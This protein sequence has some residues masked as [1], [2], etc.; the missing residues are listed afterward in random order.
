MWKWIAVAAALIAAPALAA[1]CGGT[2]LCTV[3]LG[4]YA[5]A[6]PAGAKGPVPVLLHL[7]GMGGKADAV[8]ANDM[9]RDALARGYAMIAPQGDQ[10]GTRHPQNWSVSDRSTYPRDD[11]AFVRQVL[12]DAA[13]RFPIDR[14][15]VLMSGFSRGGS[16]VW[17]I[18][19]KAPGMARAYAPVAGAFWDPLPSAC[20]GPVDM[21]HT[22]GW[23]DRVVPLEGRSF[24]DGSIVQ[25]D[26]FAALFILRA[27]DGCAKRQPE[28]APIEGNLWIRRWSDCEKGSITLVLHPEGH[29][30]PGFWTARALDWF[31]SLA[32][33]PA[34]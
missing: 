20:A 3:P 27:T 2:T 28:T 25:G 34:H 33:A 8:I 15:R 26:V 29:G 17:D 14:A 24:R 6:L 4:Q 19:C 32:A 5:I 30:V 22:H 16:M 1:E 18:A 23:T 21:L 13:A 9:T 7:H 11:T 31:E 10:P 12:D